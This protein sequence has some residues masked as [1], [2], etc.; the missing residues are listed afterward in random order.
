MTDQTSAP[1]GVFVD[2][3]PSIGID[4][5]F[6]GASDRL[7][8]ILGRYEIDGVITG[9][10]IVPDALTAEPFAD[11][12]CVMVQADLFVRVCDQ[13]GGRATVE[14]V[15][16][17]VT[18]DVDRGADGIG[19][20]D[21]HAP[22][23]TPFDQVVFVDGE[24][25]GTA[26]RR[27]PL[28]SRANPVP[29][30]IG[31]VETPRMDGAAMTDGIA[32][33]ISEGLG[34]RARRLERIRSEGRLAMAD[35]GGSAHDPALF[36]RTLEGLDKD[37]IH[38]HTSDAVDA[39]VETWS[40]M[41]SARLVAVEGTHAVAGSTITMEALLEVVEADGTQEELHVL[42][43]IADARD[44]LSTP[45]ID[46]LAR[47][48]T[49]IEEKAFAM[50]LSDADLREI[51]DI[52]DVS[53]DHLSHGWEEVDAVSL[54]PVAGTYARTGLGHDGEG[55]SMLVVA[56][57]TFTDGSRTQGHLTFVIDDP[58]DGFLTGRLVGNRPAERRPAGRL[59]RT[60]R[61][62]LTGAVL[63]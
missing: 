63:G 16:V 15:R 58:R 14:G 25:S 61:P 18:G 49:A 2:S 52:S 26:D 46:L 36:A 9:V 55:A 12:A 8:A 48:R 13:D 44:P 1:G 22:T 31:V 42:V 4:A 57:F 6:A 50:R 53:V 3:L 7:S 56:S 20:I 47:G 34:L 33:N 35:A 45:V 40:E 60:P 10:A 54:E 21:I 11:G 30:D 59:P 37:G 62:R 41:R 24:P 19:S 32:A 5:V 28:G 23:A 38:A 27:A 29:C 51:R 17:L 39:S 43:T